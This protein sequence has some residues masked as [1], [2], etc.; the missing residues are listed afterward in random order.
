[1]RFSYTRQLLPGNSGGPIISS[2]GHIVGIVT[3]DLSYKDF[4]DAPFYAGIPTSIIA[5]SLSE[6]SPD[7]KLPIENYE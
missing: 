6:I 4:S 1:M 3:H 7:I 5:K 2:S